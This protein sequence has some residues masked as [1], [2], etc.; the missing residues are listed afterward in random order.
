MRLTPYCM[1]SQMPYS[2]PSG[3]K[4]I[5]FSNWIKPQL[6]APM[7]NTSWEH[8]RMHVAVACSKTAKEK[9]DFLTPAICSKCITLASLSSTFQNTLHLSSSRPLIY[10]LHG[11][12]Q[13]D[14]LS[15]HSLHFTG[16]EDIHSLATYH[17]LVIFI[18]ALLRYKKHS[19]LHW[20]CLQCVKASHNKYK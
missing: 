2:I 10:L 17:L 6:L 20:C 9:Q 18:A 19:Q 3:N 13:H 1:S 12:Y 5:H 15:I 16:N 8:S 7:R 11:H 4:H 14:V